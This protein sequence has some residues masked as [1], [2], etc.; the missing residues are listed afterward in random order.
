MVQSQRIDPRSSTTAEALAQVQQWMRR[1]PDALASY[2]LALRLQ[3]GSYN[4]VQGRAMTLAA[5]GDLAGARAALREPAAGLERD[6]FIAS[7]ALYWDTYWLL[8]D[9]QQARLRQLPPDPFDGDRGGW[10]LA[11]AGA[12]ETIGDMARARAYADSGRA[13]FEQQLQAA[14][15]DAQRLVLLGVSLAY[16]GQGDEAVRLGLR[17]VEERPLSRDYVSGAYYAHQLARIHI[18]LGQA[19]A[20]LELLEPLLAQPYYLSPAWLRLDPTFRP[21]QSNPRF[22]RLAAQ[23]PAVH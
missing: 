17:S 19:D 15:D 16:L 3:P 7:I 21:L 10:G 4:S 1:Y 6:P 18:L 20:A 22:Q 11:L 13:A 9:D 5:M 23:A 14:P 12:Y 8:S 2:E